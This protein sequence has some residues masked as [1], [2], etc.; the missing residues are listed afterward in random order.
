MHTIQRNNTLLTF[1]LLLLTLVVSGVPGAEAKEDETLITAA[2]KPAEGAIE[3]F[4]GDPEFDT[5]QIF[6]SGR[7]PNIVVTTEGTVLAVWGDQR[8]S[9]K[10]IQVRRSEDGGTSWEP[11]IDLRKGING[12]GATVDETRGNVFVFLHT[13]GHP[14]RSPQFSMG[15]IE[16]Y[17]S[18]DD[19]K[20]WE[21]VDVNIRPDKNGHVP[22]MSMAEHG[23]TLRHGS[24]AGRLLR[25]ARVYNRPWGYNTAIYSDDGGE[26]WHT[27]DPFPE[28]GTGEGALAELSDGTIYYNSR[29]HRAPDG[30]NPRRR[31][32]AWSDDGGE[33][34]EDAGV[35]E[36]LPDG[37]QH[38][39]YGCMGGLAR[40]PVHG[41]D[42]LVFSNIVSSG[43]RKNGHAWVSFDGGKTWPLKKQIDAGS[44]AYSSLTSGRPGTPSEGWIYLLYESGGAK[45][46]RFN[47]AWLL[48]GE[49]TGDGTIPGWVS[50][51]DGNG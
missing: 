2:G 32:E 37:S 51:A 8:H 43:A 34:W 25:P 49:A 9:D 6:E 45:V 44:F 48:Q 20:S 3:P 27:S 41:R 14:P 47:L 21:Q 26:T 7:L 28:S 31:W 19:G 35:N 30:K 33:T 16:V 17:R 12:G 42:V 11:S 38:R 10:P 40:L 5:Q 15:S 18:A 4:L 46:A 24:N 36:V 50:E 29:R 13:E 22:A 23:I 1:V 39:D